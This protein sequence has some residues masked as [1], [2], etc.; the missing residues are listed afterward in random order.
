M[1]LNGKQILLIIGGGIAAYK[2]LE[3]VRR[4]REQGAGVRAILT[5]AGSRFVTPLSVA[6]LCEQPVYQDLFDLKD[7]SEMGHIRLSRQADLI[8]VCPATADLLAKMA[9]GHADDLASTVLLATDKPVMA[10]PAMNVRMW[11]HAATRR[12]V[13]RL[14]ADGVDVMEPAEGAM[15]CGEHGPGRLPEPAAILHAITA[16]LSPAERPL[17]GRRALVTAGPTREPIDP[18]RYLSNHSSGKQGFAIAGALAALGADVVLV[19][20]PVALPTPAGVTRIDVETARA[21]HAACLDALPVDVAVC[22]AAVADWRV[23]TAGQKLK[24]N[25]AAPPALH[26]VEN[27]DILAALSRPGPRRPR[28]VV[29][30]AAETEQVRDHAVAKRARKACDWIVA[31]DVSVSGAVSGGVMG[32]DTNQ[33]LLVTAEGVQNWPLMPKAAVAGQLATAIARALAA[34]SRQ[35]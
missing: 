33:V 1:M 32:A 5:A 34:P 17:A 6:A 15:A 14:R 30:F 23:E 29:G 22:V 8:V 25:G 7:E 4:L 24:K 16:R 12:N 26:L 18:V 31:N 19:A 3:L 10:V 9:G 2:T 28:L 11:T 20:G 13:E 27:P 21:M 35:G